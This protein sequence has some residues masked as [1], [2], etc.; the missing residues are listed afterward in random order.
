MLEESAKIDGRDVSREQ[1]LKYVEDFA[2]LYEI[3]R[4]QRKA[5]EAANEKLQQEIGERKRLQDELIQSEARYRSLFE[6]SSDAIYVSSRDGIL[7]DANDSFL[8]LL[9]YE[10]D[11]IIET[12]V[13][14]IWADPAAR[15]VFQEQ[16]EATGSLHD[17]E[18]RF[19][20][21]DGAVVDCIVSAT[22]RKGRDG[23][24]LGY[25]GI[26]RDVSEEKRRREILELARRM[27]ALAHMAGG[28]AHEIRNPLAISSSA[29]QLLVN[30]NI[31]RHLRK[32][33]AEKIV[34]GIS[35]AS[36]IIENLLTFAR[37]L[38]EYAT[39]EIDLVGVISNTLEVVTA[40][41]V[42]QHIELAFQPG[43]EHVMLPANAELLHRV[44]LNLFLN[45]FAAMPNGGKLLVIVDANTSEATVTVTDSGHGISEEQL[46]SIFDPFFSGFTASRGIGLGLSVACY[47]VVQHGGTIHV[48]STVADGTTFRVK[49][50]LG[51]SSP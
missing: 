36:L 20:R 10:R 34:T 40:T 33:C 26:V 17:F 38:S 1:L 32:E 47:L 29:A 42:G 11:E 16:V 4:M 14:K 22:V 35:R 41:A 45:A 8:A 28:I 21:K 5:L 43:L 46:S 19:R 37:P 12:S 49:L 31:P 13:L 30:D 23:S 39:K 9:G 7:V 15:S 24:I 3:E 6:D 50:P 2:R 51:S 27:Q 18:A 48:D 44:F 25:H